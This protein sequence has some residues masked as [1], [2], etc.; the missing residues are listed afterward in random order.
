MTYLQGNSAQMWLSRSWTQAGWHL[1][2]LKE[3]LGCVVTEMGSWWPYWDQSLERYNEGVLFPVQGEALVVLVHPV[4]TN[5]GSYW[6]F[7]LDDPLFKQILTKSTRKFFFPNLTFNAREDTKVT[8]VFCGASNNFR[9]FSYLNP[10]RCQWMV[11]SL[12]L[13]SLIYRS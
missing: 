9:V 5:S 13:F 4:F 10:R 6:V 2:K 7:G 3:V 11:T 12:M 1:V 8:L